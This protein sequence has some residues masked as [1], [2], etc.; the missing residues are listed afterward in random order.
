M[1][2]IR[3]NTCIIQCVDS[4]IKKAIATDASDIHLE[5]AADGMRMRFRVDG[6]LYD[7]EPISEDIAQQ[8]VSRIK[9]LSQTDIAEKRIPQDGRF[10]IGLDDGHQIDLRVST[11]PTIH[12]EKLVIRILNR[13]SCMID[14]DH[15]GFYDANLK[16][17]NQL[18]QK[19]SGF[20]LV[21]GPTGSGKTTTLYAALSA[22]NSP[23][24]N[25]I[26]LEDPVE[27]NLEGIIQGHIQP[28][29]GFTFERGIRAILRQDPDIAMIGEI[30]D[31]QTARIAIEA[32]LTGHLV[33]ST[34]H[35]NDA[36][37]TLMRLLD[38]GVEPFLLNASLTGILAQRLARKICTNCKISYTPNQQEIAILK[39]LGLS[40]NTLYKG[41][42]CNACFGHGVKGRT[43]LFEL[44]V[45]SN[46]LRAKLVNH[47]VFDD[48]YKQ[49]R[50]DGMQ[51]VLE[52]GLQKVADG[53]ISLSELLRVLV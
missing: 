14:L 53:V 3:H 49:A 9:I 51:T 34:L 32:A 2:G 33:L 6:V 7:Q 13:Q 16:K 21:T 5:P 23:E 45:V 30:R 4:L 20:L 40:C 37:G 31:K 27:Y 50:A 25:I 46:D 12:G 42:G 47:P 26:T 41:T 8:I 15:L 35:T 11:F 38:M 28:A 24:K 1:D 19:P 18:I 22:L 52:D 29:A 10:T 48:I 36:P 43:G 44:L 39:Q 17:F